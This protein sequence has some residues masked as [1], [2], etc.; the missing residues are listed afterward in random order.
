MAKNRLGCEVRLLTGKAHSSYVNMDIN[1]SLFYDIVKVAVLKKYD[2]NYCLRFRSTDVG[3]DET[4]KE[5]YV[6]LKDP[7]NKWVQPQNR[8]KKEVVEVI[9]MEQYLGKGDDWD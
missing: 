5:L 2:I 6:H 9:I 7:F 1:E 3:A 4:P 8:C